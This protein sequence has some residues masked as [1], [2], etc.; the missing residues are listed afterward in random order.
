MVERHD[1]VWELSL[2]T[3]DKPFLFS[4]ICGVLAY[5]GMDI[6]RGQA[7][8]TAEGLVL[9]VFQFADE[10]GFLRLNAGATGE[11]TR[12][13]EN[14]VAGSIDV[15]TLL[16]GK[17]RSVVYRRRRQGAP[18]IRFDNDHSRKYTVL[19]LVADDAPGLLHKVSRAISG[20]GCDVDL[21]L[22]AT[23]GKKA[24][25]VLHITKGGKKLNESDQVSLREDLERM[26]EDTH[27]AR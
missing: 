11:L 24:V 21:V 22:I 26:L 2:V 17:E 6:H 7:M 23:E 19:E 8:T 15:P 16:R 10:E 3:L 25:D 9:D 12:M 20:R 4:N 5:F 18:G 14:A 13:L 1:E 27:E